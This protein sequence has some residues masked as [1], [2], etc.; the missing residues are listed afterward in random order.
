MAEKLCIPNL[1]EFLENE[2][3]PDKGIGWFVP[4]ALA[5]SSAAS[6]CAPG[7]SRSAGTSAE[8]R[9][10]EYSELVAKKSDPKN[11]GKIQNI[12]SNSM[13]AAGIAAEALSLTSGVPQHTIEEIIYEKGYRPSKNTLLSLCI[14]LHLNAE[15]AQELL[16]YE[17][18]DFRRGSRFDLIVKYC[19][20]NEYFDVEGINEILSAYGEGHL[21]A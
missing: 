2:Y 14:G 5:E 6:Y 4:P 18:H 1:E 20:D 9:A 15:Q 7:S 17:G 8:P 10:N 3:L 16:N 21:G 11:D 19:L 12:I 13:K